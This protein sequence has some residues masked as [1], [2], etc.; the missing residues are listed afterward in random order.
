[1]VVGSVGC[2]CPRMKKGLVGQSSPDADV[3][4]SRNSDQLCLMH[5]ISTQDNSLPR[6]ANTVFVSKAKIYIANIYLESQSNM[7]S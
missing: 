2:D 7:L 3:E 5:Y 6:Q 1:M 4:S